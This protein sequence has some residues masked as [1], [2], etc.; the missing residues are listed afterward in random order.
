MCGGSLT[1]GGA[2]A[3]NYLAGGGG[4]SVHS[5]PLTAEKCYPD[6]LF[7]VIKMRYST[8]EAK[9][10]LTVAIMDGMDSTGFI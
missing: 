8:R 4:A 3:E 2:L 10:F 9:N 6:W 5:E 1:G 7:L